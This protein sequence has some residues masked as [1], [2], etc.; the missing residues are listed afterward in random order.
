MRSEP[1]RRIV[2]THPMTLPN[3]ARTLVSASIVA[4]AAWACGGRSRPEAPSSNPP[5]ASSVPTGDRPAWGPRPE[6]AVRGSAWVEHA[7]AAMPLRDRIAQMMLPWTPGTDVAEGTAPFQRVT[8]WVEQDHVGGIIISTGT[9]GGYAAKLNTLQRRSRIPLLVVTDL[10]SGPGMRLVAET[11]LPGPMREGG[12]TSFPPVMGLAAAGSDSLAYELGR[13]IGREARAV[14]IGLTLSPVLDVNSNPDNPIINTRSFGERPEDVA[15]LGAAYVRGVHDGGLLAA[16]K[17]FPGHGDT[18]TDSHIDLPTVDAT[19]ARLNAVDLVPFRAAVGAGMDGVLVGHIAVPAVEAGGVPASMSH[20]FSTDIL[21]G[22]LRFAG[23]VFTDAMNMGG[24]TR[25]YGEEEAAVRAVEAGADLLLQ[26]P[27]PREAIDAIERAVASGRIEPERIDQSVR[28]ILAAKQRIGLDRQPLVDRAAVDSLVGSPAHQALAREVARRS[29]T[30]VKDDRSLVPLAAA[31]NR[32]LSITYSD[33]EGRPAGEG[34]DA[35]LSGGGK[36]VTRVRIGPGTTGAELAAIR[37]RADSA[38][39]AVVSV[40]VSPQEYKGTVSTGG[41]F[42]AFV[43]G[44]ARDGRPLVV[45]SFGSPYLVS[46]FP[47]VP[48]Y[49]LAWGSCAVCQRAAADAL[50]GA[51]PITGRL[52]VS[53]PPSFAVGTGIRRDAPAMHSADATR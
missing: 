42:A 9:P 12:G 23:L 45:V 24:L 28:R 30:L 26:P 15:R 8:T 51:A 20:R 27:H 38:D 40:Y 2:K 5:G 43:E 33:R 22:D 7:L 19:R 50:L 52:P 25:R 37:R 31:A 32:I 49:V 21:R 48:A 16:G 3:A 53:L 1:N 29:I 44:M 11:E 39:V 35:A 46:G 18:H 17:H 34:F 36:Q 6:E 13:V 4:C 41:A 14:G 47:S 10:E